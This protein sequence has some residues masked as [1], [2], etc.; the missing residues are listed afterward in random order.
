V[1][2]PAQT[3]NQGSKTD[4]QRNDTTQRN[5]SG[6]T[7]GQTE[8][9]R[10]EIAGV[11]IVG[12]T[13]VD[14]ST[15]RGVVAEFTYLTI[16]GSPR[17]GNRRNNQ[18]DDASG[19]R[20]TDRNANRDQAN[21]DRNA[22]RDQAN[23]DRNANRDRESNR[24]QANQDRNANRDQA[25]GD[26]GNQDQSNDE[27]SNQRRNVYEIAIGPETQVRDESS[28]GGRDSG[29]QNDRAKGSPRER[30]QNQLDRLE[31]GDRVEVEFSRMNDRGQSGTNNSGQGA[32]ASQSRHG[33]QR[34]I[35]GLARTITIRS[36]PDQNGDQRRSE[37]R[38]G[39]DN[40]SRRQQS[41]SNP[42]EKKSDQDQ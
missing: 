22:N 41:G 2:A 11:S 21:Q 39:N 30:A 40:S 31:L 25:N 19:S 9:I 5:D 3:D 17:D 8:R 20:R 33:R 12:E 42:Q 34:I 29:N 37:D 36:T 16:L 10:G 18:A 14:Y 6:Q 26:R 4:N 38:R 27:S 7:Q 23:Q 1:F 28:Q 24:D 35:R 13:M 15:G 32:S